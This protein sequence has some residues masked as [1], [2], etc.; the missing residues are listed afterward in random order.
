MRVPQRC[1]ALSGLASEKTDSRT[2][3][4]GLGFASSPLWG[5]A[6]TTHRGALPQVTG[7]HS[8]A[9]GQLEGKAA[10]SLKDEGSR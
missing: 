2:Q 6:N 9:A 7:L 8:A 1:F 3:A 5:L 10:Y 4:V